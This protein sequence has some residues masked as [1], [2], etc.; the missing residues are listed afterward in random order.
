MKFFDTHCHLNLSPLS[1]Q[2]DTIVKQLEQQ[3][4]YVNIVGIDLASSLLAV[5]QAT[6]SEMLF[7]TI[8]I[9]PTNV[10]D[11]EDEQLIITTFE[12]LLANKV[13][14]KIIAIGETGFDFYHFSSDQYQSQKV[15][16][17]KW[18]QIHYQLAKK[19]DLPL[20]LHVRDA[21]DVMV[22]TLKTIDHYGIIHCFNQDYQTALEYLKLNNNWM[23][24]I[25]GVIT[26]KKV[27]L[28]INA[29]AQVPLDKLLIETDAPWLAPVPYRGKTNYPYY[30]K[31]TLTKIAEIKNL[32]LNAC[33]SVIWNNTMKIFKL[34]LK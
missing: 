18:F 6:K 31:A 21:H 11:I 4:C 8:G 28:L 20:M 17:E 14:N 24:S 29:V 32:D 30:S 25:P 22:E 19:Y 26:F 5:E 33:A 15:I 10:C 12:K 34:N 13:A 1:D 27:D 2:F 7:C 3:Q 23:I 16:Q 9:H